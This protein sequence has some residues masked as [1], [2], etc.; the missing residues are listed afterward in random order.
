MSEQLRRW[1]IPLV[2]V[3]SLVVGGIAVA[4]LDEGTSEPTTAS[5]EPT[6]EPTVEPTGPEAET[7]EAETPEAE[8]P[9]DGAEEPE[10]GIEEGGGEAGVERYS[11]EECGET[12]LKNHGQYVKAAEKGGEARSQA[13][14]SPCG[15]PIAAVA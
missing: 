7:P 14:Q 4:A 6:T 1:L 11:G 13:A 8:T 3:G 10:E 5:E 12:V 2:V 9:E 15:K